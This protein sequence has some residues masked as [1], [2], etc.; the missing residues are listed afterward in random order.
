MVAA[1]PVAKVISDGVG[2][3]FFQTPLSFSFSIVG[4]FIW[5]AL[6]II[7]SI[8]ASLLPAY[9]ATRLT[10]REMLAYERCQWCRVASS[11]K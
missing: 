4:T 9:P 8:V 5:L 10:V 3:A 1:V 2:M 6:V 11:A 7:I